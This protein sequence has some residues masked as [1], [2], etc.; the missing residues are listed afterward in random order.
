MNQKRV[1]EKKTILPAVGAATDPA[2][3]AYILLYD[4]VSVDSDERCK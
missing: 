4:S 2:L 3:A 1:L